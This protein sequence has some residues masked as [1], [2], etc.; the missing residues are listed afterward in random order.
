MV[1]WCV[2]WVILLTILEDQHDVCQELSIRGVLEGAQLVPHTPKVHGLPH[3][4]VVVWSLSSNK[5]HISEKNNFINDDSLYLG[6]NKLLM[7]SYINEA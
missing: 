3:H 6:A 4:L 5:H 7:K 1:L 2:F